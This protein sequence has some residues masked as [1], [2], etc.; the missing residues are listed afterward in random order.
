[1]I[2]LFKGTIKEMATNPIGS[3]FLIKI[4]SCFDDTVFV[5]KYIVNDLVT[6][7]EELI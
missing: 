2:K 1:M 6:N 7:F 5:K 3:L 4:L